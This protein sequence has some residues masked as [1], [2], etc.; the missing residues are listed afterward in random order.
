MRRRR[1]WPL[2]LL[3]LCLSAATPVAGQ[4]AP[5]VVPVLHDADL[6]GWKE[7]SFVGHTSYRPVEEDGMP[8]LHALSRGSA[9]GLFRRM[10]VDLTRTPVLHWR[11]R[12]A[13]TLGDIDETTKGGDDYAARVYVIDESVLFWRTRALNYVWTSVKPP[14]AAWPNAYAGEHAQMLAIRSGDERRGVWVEES[15]DVR[16]DFRMLFGKDVQQIDGI[17]IMTDTDDTHGTAE[18]WYGDIWFAAE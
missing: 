9:S 1:S 10:E 7:K 3:L 13:H 15:R 17:A 16:A 18:A 14:G 5:L 4:D 8:V 2:S 6:D 11:W 12:V